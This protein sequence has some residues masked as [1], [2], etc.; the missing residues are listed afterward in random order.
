MGILR[1]SFLLFA[2]FIAG[3]YCQLDIVTDDTPL[4][5]RGACISNPCLH[6]GLCTITP[7]GFICTCMNGYI[8][9][10]CERRAD[11][12]P[13]DN[14][15]NCVHGVCKLD[16]NGNP[17]CLCNEGYEG[18]ACSIATDDCASQPCLNGGTC[19]DK[20]NG[21]DCKC[22][23]GVSG[24]H[25]QIKETHIQKCISHC[26][27]YGNGGKCWH[28]GTE[29]IT[30]GWGYG[31]LICN[32]KQTCYN[33]SL[34]YD[35]SYEYISVQLKPIH[36]QDTDDLVF[37]TDRDAVLYDYNFIPHILPMEADSADSFS[38]CN[39]TNAIPLTN[40]PDISRLNVNDSLLK[41]GT[42]YF[43]ADTNTLHR[44]LFG[45]RLNV[46]VKDMDCVNP[47][48]TAIEVFCSG[49]GKCFSDFNRMRYEC[50][51]CDGFTGKYCQYED[52]C[53]VKPCANSAKC[54]I[55]D[56][57]NGVLKHKCVCANGFHGKTCNQIIDFCSSNPCQNGAACYSQLNGYKCQCRLGFS[58]KKCEVNNDECAVSPCRNNGTC[59]DGL[60][61]FRCNCQP[62]FR[63]TLCEVNTNEC[64][65]QPCINGTC[66]D[67]VNNYTC[68]CPAGFEG[69]NCEI[70]LD[71]CKSQ[72]CM[73]GKCIKEMN[74][75]FC[76]C[77]IGYTGML[78]ELKVNLCE[79]SQYCVF[80]HQ[81]TCVD[82]GNN[83][84]CMCLDGWS[85]TNCAV[86]IDDCTEHKCINAGKCVDKVD[87]YEC[88][89]KKG[90]SGLY[91]EGSPPKNIPDIEID[92]M[93]D[94]C[95]KFLDLRE[96][97]RLEQNIVA[98]LR[99]ACKCS[100]TV[101][102]LQFGSTKVVCKDDM[103]G[104]F[105]TDLSTDDVEF[106][107][108]VVCGMQNT[109]R[110]ENT[111]NIYHNTYLVSIV[112]NKEICKITEKRTVPTAPTDTSS[113]AGVAVGVI[114]SF[115]VLILVLVFITIRVRNSRRKKVGVVYEFQKEPITFDNPAFNK[116]LTKDEPSLDETS[117][118]SA[119]DSLDDSKWA[120][121]YDRAR[122]MY[123]RAGNV[124]AGR[125]FDIHNPAGPSTEL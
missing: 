95:G 37:I 59:V 35:Q 1:Q 36:M 82:H 3:L 92:F 56:F 81:K 99:S 6:N 101:K 28:H 62:G 26:S 119:N 108:K 78:C 42:Q 75:F 4:A 94:N 71:E 41:L 111:P 116:K 58:G 68:A 105:M 69:R 65:H 47:I 21:F 113:T 67:M 46:T 43:F 84:T 88:Q 85:G 112:D 48:D 74:G 49:H 60:N 55:M 33:M 15:M 93:T 86:N 122:Q 100:L 96:V 83:V 103:A 29:N 2:G 73:H 102:S 53:Y 125:L 87:G 44:C 121:S 25:C 30:V 5:L 39:T 23:S 11:D 91:C 24:S 70:Q 120:H 51:C 72:P 118:I 114:V 7:S 79:H 22:I 16:M 17:R 66:L 64:K 90:F 61:A 19:T 52:P 80:Q 9:V 50:L 107:R 34:R 63:G 18:P 115:L 97:H 89:C 109:I 106:Q 14:A 13:R 98:L 12:C 10:R 27:G 8:G 54:E 20:N 32:S 110:N 76:S 123:D 77:G 31:E 104:K 117:F 40:N 124:P 38:S 45:L 57:G